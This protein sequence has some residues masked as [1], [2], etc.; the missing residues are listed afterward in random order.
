MSSNY[1]LNLKINSL[2]TQLDEL[3]IYTGFTYE[4]TA[5]GGG[6]VNG[7]SFAA[8]LG[9][10][11]AYAFSSV[12][13]NE[14]WTIT[15]NV[16]D[17]PGNNMFVGVS[18]NLSQVFP[19]SASP[20]MQMV[21]FGLLI[22][23][24][25][26]NNSL[27][28][29][30]DGKFTVTAYQ[31]GTSYKMTYDGT[32]ISVFVNNI[33]LYTYTVSLDPV[34]LIV[35]SFFGGQVNNISFEGQGEGGGSGGTQGLKDVLQVSNDGGDLDITNVK[36]VSLNGYLEVGDYLQVGDNAGVNSQFDMAF[37]NKRWKLFG[38]SINPSQGDLSFQFF[39]NNA[40]V[41]TPFVI[42]PANIV[43]NFQISA[44]DYITDNGTN[45]GVV[46][47]SLV[48]LPSVLISSSL[49]N[50]QS[51]SYPTNTSTSILQFHT[52]DF[53]DELNNFTLFFKNLSFQF[54]V[55]NGSNAVPVYVQLFLSDTLNGDFDDS[56]PLNVSWTSENVSIPTGGNANVSVNKV[57]L[58]LLSSKT[59][60]IDGIYLNVRTNSTDSINTF[61][62]QDWTFESQLNASF[63]SN[64]NQNP[65]IL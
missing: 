11:T 59:P 14:P 39:N 53:N 52:E 51:K 13:R 16:Q 10:R 54:G 41:S 62:L 48:N 37:D 33:Q 65:D 43:S 1:L 50:T 17:D 28:Q 63:L 19:S 55:T 24:K 56:N 23:Y 57:L 9:N 3:S 46:F 42:K 35:G 8:P 5:T 44:P 12:K 15:F 18:Q 20:S 36:N 6:L 7:T 64:K 31:L 2:Q 22:D 26:P 30:V 38:S 47:D 27:I 25:P 58:G 61:Q 32:A 49:N 45:T 34:Y 4:L 21:D 29:I 40:L 60:L